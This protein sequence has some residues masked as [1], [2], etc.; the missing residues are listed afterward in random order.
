M[1]GEQQGR[2][3]DPGHDAGEL[4]RVEHLTTAFPTR[5]G[6]VRV[7][8]D[9]SFAIRRGEI[10]GLVGESGSGKSMTALSIMQLVPRPGRVVGGRV[11]FRG[12]NLVA[13]SEHEMQRVRGAHIGLVMQDPMTSLN[14]VLRVGDQVAELYQ[15]H[16]DRRPEGVTAVQ[17][18]VDQ[19]SRVRIP[20]PRLRVRDFP[21]AFSGGMRQRVSIAMATA[22][23]P[24]L[25]IADEPTTALDVTIQVQILQ[26]LLDLRDE[27]GIGV[28]FITHDLGIVAEICDAVAVMYAG[29]IVEY[30]DI[31]T[32]FKHP[33]HPYTRALLGSLPRVGVR[34]NRLPAIEGQPPSMSA[35]P[36][37]CRFAPRCPLAQDRCRTDEPSPEPTGALGG[38]GFVRC[39]VAAEA[40]SSATPTTEARP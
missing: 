1:A 4:L 10:V 17:A 11:T 12:Q 3:L 32:I 9:V 14:P 15:A 30:G 26:L 40:L 31:E 28:L 25:I 24:D 5:R 22:C 13:L 6:P 36:P 35:L 20:A 18:V 29:R 23:R 16:A 34:L 27:L 21:F 37:G 8:D 7:V 38:R 39:W 19:L 33:R 2:G